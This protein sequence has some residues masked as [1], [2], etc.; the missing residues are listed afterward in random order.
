MIKIDYDDR[1]EVYDDGA[2]TLFKSQYGTYNSRSREG[3]SLC[4]GIDKE[5]VIFWSREH[6][7]GFQNSYASVVK[8]LS[9]YKL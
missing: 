7:N 8:N 5:A 2:F 9:N 4:C 6:I 3:D 1:M